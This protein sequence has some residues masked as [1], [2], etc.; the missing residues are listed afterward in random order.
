MPAPMESHPLPP[1]VQPLPGHPAPMDDARTRAVRRV[2]LHV[3]VVNALLVGV[4]LFIGLQAHALTVLGAAL[5][6]GL[7]VLNNIAGITLIAVAG[8]GP[9]EDHPYG[10]A[11]FESVATLGIV[12]FLSI[13]CF[14]LLQRGVGALA[15]G[16]SPSV[17]PATDVAV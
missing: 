4:K 2:L 17:A 1:Q 3:L 15:H 13:S 6:S 5:E 12:G 11:K 10:H 7:D 9:D 16:T 14:E 8:R